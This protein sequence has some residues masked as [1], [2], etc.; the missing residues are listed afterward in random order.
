[1]ENKPQKINEIIP[2]AI[3]VIGKT[4][5]IEAIRNDKIQ[6]QMRGDIIK[7]DFNAIAKIEDK[8][9]FIDIQLKEITKTSESVQLPGR[10]FPKHHPEVLITLMKSMQGFINVSNKMSNQ[11]IAETCDLLIQEHPHLSL[12]DFALFFRKVKT[13]YYGDVYGRLDGLLIM[14]MI[15]NFSHNCNYQIVLD[16]EAE[17]YER[18]RLTEARDLENYYKDI[19]PK[20][21]E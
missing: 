12:Q 2:G 16:D 9:K 11:Q 5:N 3:D 13:G 14:A 15:K 17:H 8:A 18:K 20:I 6:R 10:I 1:M 19:E 7:K 21:K 4:G